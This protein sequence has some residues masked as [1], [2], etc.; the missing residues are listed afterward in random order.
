MEL[1]ENT[2]VI[3][4]IDGMDIRLKSK[5]DFSFLGRY[6]RVFRVFDDQD[7]GN[8]C[9]GIEKDN[10]RYFL[11]HA[12]APALRANV[13]AEAAVTRM[14]Q[15]VQIYRDLDHPA[16]TR[17]IKAEPA[18][19]GYV[20]VFEWNDGECMGK[21]Y[22]QSREKF[23]MLP[24]GDRLPVFDEILSFHANAAKH[25]YAAIDFYDGSIMYDFAAKKTFIC[26]I[27]FY[28]KMPYVNN[29]GR[30][31]GSSRFMSPEEFQQ[32]A[33]IDEITNVYTMGA[34]AFALFCGE[35]TRQFEDWK[36]NSRLFG[37]AEKAVSNDRLK[38][39]QS[40]AQFIS[41]WN[42]AGS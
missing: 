27:E 12:G 11:K 10:A 33:V 34:V 15:S 24:I 36:L 30:M 4:Q 1:P 31:W 2:A 22:P 3:Q 40:I 8:I 38:R 19:N 17:L 21:Q 28:A 6:G 13:S 42:N 39:Q 35:K 25:G 26:D 7:S 32:G 9:F 37:V 41:E 14:K 23:F 5:F 18:G 29:M 16:L 20:I